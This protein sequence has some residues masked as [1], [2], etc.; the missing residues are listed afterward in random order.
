MGESKRKDKIDFVSIVTPNSTHFMIAKTFLE[1][2]IN[3]VCDKPLCF[4]VE[5]AKELMDLAKQKDLLFMVTYTYSGYPMVQEARE[6]IK[7]GAIGEIRTVMAQY[8]QEWL[9]KD[10]EDENNKQA[11]WRLE[12][13]LA[14]KSS[15]VG[16]IGS[17]IENTVKRITGLKITKLLARLENIPHKRKLDTNAQIMVEYDNG[18]S[19]LYWSSQIAPGHENGLKVNVYG[20]KGSIFWSQEDPNSL[21]LNEVGKPQ[22]IYTRGNDYLHDSVKALSRIPS[23]HPEGYYEAFSNLYRN[24]ADALKKK[25]NR[26]DYKGIFFPD[27]EDGLDGVKFINA[28][29]ESSRLNNKWVEL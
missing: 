4:E 26:E 9:V 13:G 16:D 10:I 27:A 8:P 2:G 11:S 28:C 6:L 24:F 15:C 21:I 22:K 25:K 5:E 12:P 23:G 1:A 3:V 7:E 14:G 18:A 19:G 29:V 17:H 20:E